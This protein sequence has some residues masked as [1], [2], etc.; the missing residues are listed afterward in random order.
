MAQ[1]TS[2]LLMPRMDMGHGDMDGPECKISM[3]WNWYTI[4]A[5]FIHPSW[6]ITTQGAFAATCIGIMLMVVLLEFLRR[7]GKEYDEWIVRDF[8]RRS[9][10][11]RE[12]QRRLRQQQQRQTSSTS[13][14]GKGATTSVT[15]RRRGGGYMS[16]KATTTTLKFRASPLQQLIRAVIHAVMFGLGYLVMLLAMYYNGYVI[17]SILIGALIGKFL[18][19]WLTVQFEIPGGDEEEDMDMDGGFTDEVPRQQGVEDATVCCG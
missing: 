16:T 5:C 18:C 17:I 9:A 3:L 7:L 11:I 15:E 12:Q 10:L 19:D 8:R 4:D 6:Q 14:D 1:H 13:C 2:T